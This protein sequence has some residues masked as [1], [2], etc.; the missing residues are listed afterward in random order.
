MEKRI[1]LF[2][3]VLIFLVLSVFFSCKNKN[4]NKNII[5]AIELTENNS[6]I[7]DSIKQLKNKGVN[8]LVCFVKSD[9][10]YQFLSFNLVNDPGTNKYPYNIK[11]NFEIRNIEGIDILFK[12]SKDKF[13]GQK[14]KSE[15]KVQELLNKKIICFDCKEWFRDYYFVEFIF[16]KNNYNNF[17]SFDSKIQNKEEEIKYKEEKPY[18]KEVFYPDCN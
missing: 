11:T 14:K 4:S 16:C 18:H 9:E 7:K 2:K 5:K 13:F 6:V 3:I 1:Y 17:K 15:K 10:S 8:F 12:D